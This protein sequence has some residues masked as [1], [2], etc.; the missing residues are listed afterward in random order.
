MSWSLVNRHPHA[1]VKFL[2]FG[3]SYKGCYFNRGSYLTLLRQD[4]VDKGESIIGVK[5][6]QAY[7]D[8]AWDGAATAIAVTGEWSHSPS[9][10][11]CDMATLTLSTNFGD[12]ISFNKTWCGNCTNPDVVATLLREVDGKVTVTVPK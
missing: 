7:V 1:A 3:L 8:G 11:G 12:S 10:V 2:E 9:V 6:G 5:V 4:H